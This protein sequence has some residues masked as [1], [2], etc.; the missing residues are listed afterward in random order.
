M[1][2]HIPLR[3]TL[4]ALLVGTALPA[5]AATPIDQTRPLDARGTVE[6]DN[7][8]G[9]IQVRTW[10]RP[11]VQVR[12]SLGNGV[13]RLRIEGGG[14]RLEVKVEYPR[15]SNRSEP[16]ILVL[17]VPTLASLEI[18]SVAADVDVAGVAGRSLEIDSVSGSITAI[19]APQEVEIDSVSGDQRL[20]LNS[21]MVGLDSVSGAVA[22]RGRIVGE[23][24][25][26]TVSGE[27]E[28]D[29][30]GGSV[31]RL[32]SSSVSGDATIATGL[33][34]G[35]RISAESVSGNIRITAPRNLSARVTGESFSGDL[36]APSA[37]IQRAKYGPGAS[38]E[39]RYG[40]GR[41]QI[42]LETFSGDAE[43]RLE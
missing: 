31:R 24:S 34:E 33:V 1:T 7:Q 36:S 26:E 16:S 19:G 43:L 14:P 2:S 40:E 9:R 8:K 21:R 41:G 13:E 37:S 11:E 17:M 6:I 38:F 23:I 22:L 5:W 3:T 4:L 28:I 25:V 30:R 32:D 18:E 35:G 20:N 12:G 29:S 39:H 27:I 15:N 10:D 42:R